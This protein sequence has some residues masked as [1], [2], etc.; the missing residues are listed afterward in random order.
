VTLGWGDFWGEWQPF[1]CF[2]A[3]AD[4]F[5]ILGLERFF[6]VGLVGFRTVLSSVFLLLS[7]FALLLY[8]YDYI[9]HHFSLFVNCF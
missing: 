5:R 3:L 6:S 4:F 9:I 1:F 8:F 7:L 2:S